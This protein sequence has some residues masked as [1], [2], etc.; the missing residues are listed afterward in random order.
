MANNRLSPLTRFW[1]YV[2]KP[3]NPNACWMWTG[4]KTSYGYGVLSV[5]GKHTRAHRFAYE[6]L[7]GPIPEGMFV[8]HHCDNPACVNPVHL[9]L[10]TPQDN[11]RDM[12]A[13]KRDGHGVTR[14]A[15]DH[16]MAKLTWAQVE[17]IRRLRAAGHSLQQLSDMFDVTMANISYIALFQTWKVKDSP[18]HKPRRARLT[19]QQITEIR[20]AYLAHPK[21]G[22]LTELSKQYDI[23]L[24]ATW[25]AAHDA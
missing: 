20:E 2:D 7:V 16:P 1:S 10:G 23:S 14:A 9:F 11:T 12:I 21:H 18:V 17:E 24:S 8:C 4:C 3:D 15:E 5:N 6:L 25:R 22:R 19:P 13:K